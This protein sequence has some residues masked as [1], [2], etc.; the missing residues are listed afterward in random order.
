MRP[1]IS[2]G[3]AVRHALSPHGLLVQYSQKHPEALPVHNY[4]NYLVYTGIPPG[5]VPYFGPRLAGIMPP[6]YTTME[7]RKVAEGD[8]HMLAAAKNLKTGVFSRWKPDWEAAAHDYE[9]A[10]TAYRVAKALPQ[11]IDAFCKTA[12]AHEQFDSYFMAAKHLESAAF[13]AKELRNPGHAAALYVRSAELHKLGGRV[14][15]AAET[16]GKAART[17][18][19]SGVAADVQQGAELMNSACELFVD[20]SDELSAVQQQ[21]S[22]ETYQAAVA[23]MLR[24]KEPA[25]AAALLRHQALACAR[26]DQPHRVAACELSAVVAL[27]AADDFEAAVSRCNEAQMRGDG[28][29]GTDEA[30]AASELLDAFAQQDAEALVACTSLQIF[31]FLDNLVTKLARSLTLKSVCVPP[32]R[33]VAAASSFGGAART[34]HTASAMVGGED[35]AGPALEAGTGDFGEMAPEEEAQEEDEVDLT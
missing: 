18:E 20:A 29:G 30:S 1:S 32:H 33:L 4:R 8:A 5:A 24:A 16:Y 14:D 34:T 17:L 13:L 7:T 6:Q 9:K 35:A 10:A 25:K 26:I 11:A 12:E 28:F 19:A 23:Y 21:T 2:C 31:T 27:L 3:V 15:S 22:L